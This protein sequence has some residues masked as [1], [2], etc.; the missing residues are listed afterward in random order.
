MIQKLTLSVSQVA[1]VGVTMMTVRMS[2]QFG[3][4]KNAYSKQPRS[5]QVLTEYQ[6]WISRK[7]TDQN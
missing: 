6:A 3:S 1:M 2:P 5:S 7:L 4:I